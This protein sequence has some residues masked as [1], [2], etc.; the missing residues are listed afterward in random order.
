MEKWSTP[1]MQHVLDELLRRTT[2][3]KE[4]RKL[5][6][7]DATVAFAQIVPKSLPDGMTFRFVDNEGPVKT[8]PI[9]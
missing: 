3:D 5:A 2:N 9:A 1:E 7:K 4:F 8:I 6:L